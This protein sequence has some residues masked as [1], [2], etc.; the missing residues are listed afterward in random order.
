[1]PSPIVT[2]WRDPRGRHTKCT[3]E[4]TDKICQAVRAGGVAEVAARSAGVAH[5]TF[6]Q[7]MARGVGADPRRPADKVFVEFG[8]AIK[9]AEADREITIVATIRS[10]VPDNWQAGAFLLERTAPERWA[11]PPQ[12]IIS[13]VSGPGGAPMQHEVR[14]NRFDALTQAERE[15][16]EILQAKMLGITTPAMIMA[17]EDE[18]VIDVDPTDESD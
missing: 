9:K 2:R 12:R 16:Y 5:G 17:L 8:D 14:V 18:N 1:M 3:P 15:Q 13:E 10:Q 6:W 7:W 4:L 11:R